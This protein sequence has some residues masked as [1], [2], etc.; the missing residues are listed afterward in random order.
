[1]YVYM[2]PLNPLIPPSSGSTVQASFTFA[3][4]FVAA[5]ASVMP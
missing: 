4:G 2:L 3:L 1:M 5:Q